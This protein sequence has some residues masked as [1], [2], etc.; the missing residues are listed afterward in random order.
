MKTFVIRYMRAF[1]IEV[2]ADSIE[3][4]A[5]RAQNMCKAWLAADVLLLSIH[6]KGRPIVLPPPVTP[7][8]PK[9]ARGAFDWSAWKPPVF[10]PP[11][12]RA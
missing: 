1:E 11:K 7:K 6:E 10:T 4:T 12:S 5:V 3:A 2:E 8:P 9:P